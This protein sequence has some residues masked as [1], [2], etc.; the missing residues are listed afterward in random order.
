VTEL[1]GYQPPVGIETDVEAA[2]ALLAEAGYANGEGLPEITFYLPAE[3]SEAETDRVRSVLD[4]LGRNLG[5]PLLF[6]NTRPWSSWSNCGR[7]RGAVRST[8]SGGRT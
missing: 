2:V 6:D 4:M 7:T 3:E 5:I 8:S 1:S